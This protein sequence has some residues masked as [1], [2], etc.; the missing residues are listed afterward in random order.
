MKKELNRQQQIS[1]QR[2]VEVLKRMCWSKKAYQT[3]LEA[4]AYGKWS[5]SYQPNLRLWT[6]LCPHCKK[7]HLT[8]KGGA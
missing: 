7:W 4:E 2:N 6:Y 8:K 1:I 3:E 5:K